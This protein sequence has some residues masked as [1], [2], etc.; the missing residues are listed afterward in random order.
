MCGFLLFAWFSAPTSLRAE[1]DVSPVS[2]ER[3]EFLQKTLDDEYSHARYWYYGFTG[4]YITATVASFGVAA[5]T[6][7]T[8]LHITQGVS[9]WQSLL[10][11]AGMLLGPM[12]SAS[13]APEI[14][15]M[16][17]ESDTDRKTKLKAAEDAVR[18]SAETQEFT[19]S[20]VNHA[21]SIGVAGIGA[22]VIR[23]SY[24]KRIDR[25]G[26][27]GRSVREAAVSFW[28][29][30]LVSEIQIWSMPTLSLN[31]WNEYDHKYHPAANA[32]QVH[33]FFI[34]IRDQYMAG[35]FV[36]F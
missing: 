29:S 1:P 30:V 4:L 34:P 36:N 8:V 27:G 11:T 25:A 23:Y 31:K 26:G 5:S 9:G 22:A 6:K 2:T 18:G 15:T 24:G 32:A 16:P 14:R 20:W 12:P 19:R 28:G 17:G 7:D 10:A 35:I 21:I 13:A 33:F 3:I